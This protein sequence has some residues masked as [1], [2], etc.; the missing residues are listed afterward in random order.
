MKLRRSILDWICDILCWIPLFTCFVFLAVYW[1]RIPDQVP[2]HYDLSGNVTEYGSKMSFLIMPFVGLLAYVLMRV[3]EE[4]PSAWNIP[5]RMTR[6]NRG[7][8]LRATK[9]MMVILKVELVALFSILT[10][11]TVFGVSVGKISI[12]IVVLIGIT[13]AVTMVRIIRTR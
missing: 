5:V 11:L 9:D 2:S 6:E 4:F 7:R 13:I 8:I 1:K 3:V 12:V 10:I